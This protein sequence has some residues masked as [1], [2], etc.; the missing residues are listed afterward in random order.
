MS[1]ISYA[2]IVGSIMY[3]ML[4]TRPDVAYSLGVV[5]RYQSDPGEAHWKVV[6]SILKYLRNTKDQWSVYGE[7]DLKLMGF[8]DS[9]F[10]SDHDDSRNMSGYI[11]TLNSG[12][13]C[14]KS[15]K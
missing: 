10:Q 15:F 1:R 2:S 6:K 4:C 12:A 14:W 3:A 13:I 11:F 9:S 7:S 5:S 8:T